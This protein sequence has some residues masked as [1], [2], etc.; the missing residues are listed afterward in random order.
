MSGLSFLRSAS[1]RFSTQRIVG[2]V[3]SSCG[4]RFFS[5]A[6]AGS[7]A[8]RPPTAIV[9]MNM[10]G[11]PKS[12]EAGKFLERLFS[13]KMIINLGPMQFLGPWIARRRTEK[14]AKQYAEIGGSPIRKWTE[15]QGKELCALADK[16]SPATAP[17]KPYVMFRYADP[18]TEETL[19][20]M[21]KDGVE[22]AVAFSQYPQYS[23]TTTGSCAACCRVGSNFFVL[24]SHRRIFYA[25]HATQTTPQTLDL[26]VRASRT[27]GRSSSAWSCP[28]VSAGA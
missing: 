6:A 22:R 17:H 10:G 27:C 3:S 2:V 14:V 9:M 1:A 28:S 12:E 4:S 7:S 16:L 25:C 15:L 19:L 13:D 23:C 11:P 18:L 26:Q 20:E 8:S 5:S 24:V 21:K